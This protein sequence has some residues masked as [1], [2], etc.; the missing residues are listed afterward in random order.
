MDG[1]K[2]KPKKSSE[3]TKKTNKTRKREENRSIGAA[4]NE[5]QAHDRPS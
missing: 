1:K 5:K 2:E 4:Y 3:Q